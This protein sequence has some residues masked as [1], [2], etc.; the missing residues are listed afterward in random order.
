MNKKLKNKKINKPMFSP[1]T[2][3]TKHLYQVLPVTK[4][5]KKKVSN[6]DFEILEFSQYKLI[7]KYNY[8]VNQLKKICKFY[9]QKLSGNKKELLK[10]V[11]NFLKFS[12]Y[13][14]KIQTIFKGYLIRK[15]IS[16]HGPA[17][18]D[19]QKSV[20]EID[21][22]SLNS[23]NDIPHYQFISYKDKNGF[24]YSF[25]ICSLYNLFKINKTTKKLS[26]TSKFVKNPYNRCDFPKDML[27]KLR[28]LIR[29][30]R[31]LKYPVNIGLTNYLEAI[32]I[33]K[34]I[35]NKI[36]NIFQKIDD[37][38][39]YTDANW[40]LSLNKDNLIKYIKQL[41][42]IW[43]Y[44]A[45]LSDD[46]KRKICP[47]YGKPFSQSNLQ[48][49]R[50]NSL[51]QIQHII[52]N[53]IETLVTKGIDVASQNLGAFYCLAAL[54]LVNSDAATALPWLYDSVLPHN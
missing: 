7:L 27:T 22:L 17:L 46:N 18:F 47:P 26:K 11:Y 19:R 13:A 25:N 5:K 6:D 30:C 23:I 54:T 34:K 36:K 37:L 24:I 38:G 20:N 33:E 1:K 53:I 10:R 40:F 4:H 16:Y 44:R 45:Q 42:D 29:L 21:F 8:N 50:S 3:L 51:L 31:I 15:Y 49:L 12:H 28:N 14:V 9:K 39:N 41:Y 35:Q 2:Y 32:S 43:V 52:I 48:H